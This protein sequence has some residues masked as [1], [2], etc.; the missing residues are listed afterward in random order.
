MFQL[1]EEV[2]KKDSTDWKAIIVQKIA[3]AVH[4]HL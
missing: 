4:D 2:Q 3:A 1:S